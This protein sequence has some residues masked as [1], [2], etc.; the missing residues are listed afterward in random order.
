MASCYQ[1]RLRLLN[2]DE[3]LNLLQV[4]LRLVSEF[5]QFAPFTRYWLWKVLYY[6]DSMATV[7][8]STCQVAKKHQVSILSKENILNN[9]RFSKFQ[10]TSAFFHPSREARYMPSTH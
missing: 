3:I 10:R 2:Q 8:F 9:G 6:C 4:G 1:R 5:L 7:V